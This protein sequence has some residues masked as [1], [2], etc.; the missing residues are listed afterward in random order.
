MTFPLSLDD[1]PAHAVGEYP[2][3]GKVYYKEDLFVGYRYFDTKKVEPLFPFGHGLSY[4]TFEFSDLLVEKVGTD[5]NISLTVTNTGTREGSEVV[6]LYV[7]DPK[8]SLPR[9]DKELKSFT[10]VFLRPAQS[11]RVTLVLSENAFQY[12]DDKQNAWVLEP[13]VFKLLVG[14]SSKGIKLTAEITF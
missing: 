14:N 3:S 12:F 4:T 6:Q 8:S 7:Q 2:G 9:P 13:G 1:S 10:K 11:E 5:I